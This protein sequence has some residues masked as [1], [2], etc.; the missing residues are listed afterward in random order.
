VDFKTIINGMPSYPGVGAATSGSTS[1][2]QGNS[3]A[4][5][6]A[7]FA[8]LM[9]EASKTPEERARD[10]VLK[11]HNMSEADYDRLPK[12]ARAG[13]DSEIAQAVKR[14]S[15]QRRAQ[16]AARNGAAV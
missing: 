5:L 15:E 11:K 10:A 1:K 8:N 2:A 14:V 3:A 12:D 9:K 7:L 6:D 13:I 16:A 4:D